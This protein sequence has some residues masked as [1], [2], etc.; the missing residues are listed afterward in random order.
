LGVEEGARG[1][2]E[3]RFFIRI[4]YIEVEYIVKKKLELEGQ[5]RRGREDRDRDEMGEADNTKKHLMSQTESYYSRN[6]L[7]YIHI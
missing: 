5:R 6:V 3:E 4:E 7:K 2:E 1:G